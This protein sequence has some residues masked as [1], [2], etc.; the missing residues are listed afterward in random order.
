MFT[1][2]GLD[3]TSKHL[4]SF[5]FLYSNHSGA[6]YVRTESN[7]FQSSYIREYEKWISIKSI[8]ALDVSKANDSFRSK[9]RI[10]TMA[11]GS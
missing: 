11:A 7:F 1:L 5:Y 4:S 8:T 9:I 2:E 3:R 6:Q 10:E